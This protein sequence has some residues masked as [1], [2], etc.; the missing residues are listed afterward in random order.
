MLNRNSAIDSSNSEKSE[1]TK[2]GKDRTRK[3]IS[4]T[5]HRRSKPKLISPWHQ[6]ST[7][8]SP[9]A[10]LSETPPG[11][12]SQT[13]DEGEAPVPSLPDLNFESFG[14]DDLPKYMIVTND[15]QSGTGNGD[16][17]ST[18]SSISGSA[19]PAKSS[20][21]TPSSGARSYN[22]DSSHT[23]ALTKS[24]LQ[25]ARP[26]IATGVSPVESMANRGRSSYRPSVPVGP[27]RK[28]PIPYK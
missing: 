23:Q 28:D 2:K 5:L 10:P 9:P 27:R 20:L 4:D 11:P 3:G 12:L 17:L 13:S 14:N 16:T 8:R 21:A 1:P 7:P 24:R 22:K 26:D 19:S 15:S 25:S 6:F 18:A